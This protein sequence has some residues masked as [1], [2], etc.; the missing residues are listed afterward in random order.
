[1]TWTA[2]VAA[3]GLWGV[4]GIAFLGATL[5]PI[6]SEAAVVAALALG[7]PA[8]KVFWSA[9]AGNAL[10]ALLDYGIGWWLAPRVQR[11]LEES[12]AGRRALRWAERYGAWSLLGAWLPIVGDPLCLVG[13]LLRMRLHVFIALG[14]GTRVA[15]YG[16]LWYMLGR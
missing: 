8:D 9:S 2:W 12:R 6:S 16:V 5:V 13:G 7:L 3:Y 4:G 14:I 11:Q 10:G 1:M 15:R